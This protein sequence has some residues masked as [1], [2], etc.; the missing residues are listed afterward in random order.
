MNLSYYIAKQISGNKQSTF[1]KFILRLATIATALSVTVMIIAISVVHGFKTKIREKMF[2]FWGH[3]QVSMFSANP[4]SLIGDAPF[5]KE[6]QLIRDIRS[7]NGV[8]S[9]YPFILK[10]AIVKAEKGLEGIKLKGVE[11]DYP[12]SS[13]DAIQFSGRPVQFADTGYSSDL[14]LS[15]ATMNRLDLAIGDAVFIVFFNPEQG[16]PTV[17]KLK[18]A[19]SFHTGMEEVDKGFGLCDIRLLRAVNRWGD[20]DISALQIGLKDYR[21]SEQVSAQVYQDYLQ[22]PMSVSTIREIYPYIFSWL[23]F[24]NTNAAL[25][26]VIMGVVAAINM[27]TALLIYILERT[28]MVG[29]LKALG[30]QNRQIRQV[31]LYH[32][33]RVTLKGILWG[34]VA[35]I[36]L[37]WLQLH[38]SLIKLDESVYYMKTAPVSIDWLYILLV[39]LGTLVFCT[40]MM[41]IPALIVGRIK[42]INALKFK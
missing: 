31:F 39:T 14:I 9:V 27:A 33:A 15:Q 13:S 32:A 21:E 5:P 35:G 38:Y 8:Q 2:V 4:S 41:L 34:L 1:S 12:M 26:L 28:Q 29:T 37:C 22:P 19:G 18:V 3:A 7:V 30:M 10:P 25:I 16:N 23:D 11:P 40:L 24:Q 20:Q 17:R 42:V 36:L 6:E